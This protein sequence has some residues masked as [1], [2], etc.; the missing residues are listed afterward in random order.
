[1]IQGVGNHALLKIHNTR[2][3]LWSRGLR[4]FNDS[5]IDV[6]STIN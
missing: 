2:K 1:M 4:P 5:Q 3:S 6:G